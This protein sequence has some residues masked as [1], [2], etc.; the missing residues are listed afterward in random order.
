[1]GDKDTFQQ[2]GP[3]YEVVV[4]LDVGGDP[5]TGQ[6][7]VYVGNSGTGT[8]MAV[9]EAWLKEANAITP[10]DLKGRDNLTAYKQDLIAQLRK[11]GSLVSFDSI[12]QVLNEL[13]APSLGM[14][15]DTTR[16]IPPLVTI[17]K[18][19]GQDI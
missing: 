19:P 10:A 15:E 18:G 11:P 8:I 13:G 17:P 2:T 5:E 1:M 4:H 12:E 16:G 3:S 6:P 9:N 7:L 14:Y